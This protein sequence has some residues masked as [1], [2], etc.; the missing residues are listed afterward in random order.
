MA[1]QLKKLSKDITLINY[2]SIMK[3]KVN[4]KNSIIKG[5]FKSMAEISRKQ[6][7]TFLPISKKLKNNH[8]QDF[9]P[10]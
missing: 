6:G 7:K 4:V 1:S 9:K 2:N 5:N 3:D 8:F 10:S